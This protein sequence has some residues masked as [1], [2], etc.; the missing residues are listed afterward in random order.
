MKRV[1][2]MLL[3]L[4]V[5]CGSQDRNSQGLATDAPQGSTTADLFTALENEFDTVRREIQGS[6]NPTRRFN[7]F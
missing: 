6:E 5:G 7:K 1:F 2:G 4:V 3:V